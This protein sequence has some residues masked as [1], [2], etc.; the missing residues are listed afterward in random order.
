MLIVLDGADA[1][2]LAIEFIDDGSDEK[3]ACSR[4]IRARS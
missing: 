2:K 4:A 3:C 1:N